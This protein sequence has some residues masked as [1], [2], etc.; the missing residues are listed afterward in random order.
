MQVKKNGYPATG[1]SGVRS[2]LDCDRF[3]CGAS[4]LVFVT[5]SQDVLVCLLSKLTDVFAQ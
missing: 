2:L 1:K 3:T 5:I 4:T